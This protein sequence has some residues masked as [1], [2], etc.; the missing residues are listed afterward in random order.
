MEQE[1][2]MVSD[3][4]FEKYQEKKSTY[5]RY[6]K[7]ILDERRRMLERTDDMAKVMKKGEYYIEKIQEMAWFR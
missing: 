2:F 1:V 4:V 6:F 7:R 3:Q 5:D